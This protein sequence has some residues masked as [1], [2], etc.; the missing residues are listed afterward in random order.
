MRELL[1][2][3]PA[4]T[5][6]LTI[7]L[8]RDFLDPS[9]ARAPAAAH[10][11]ER[12]VANI[13]TMLQMCRE[14]G[15]PVVDCYVSR[16]PQ[17]AALGGHHAPYSAAG[18]ARCSS[19]S[20]SASM[21]GDDRHQMALELMAGGVAGCL[22][23]GSCTRN[24]PSHT[25]PPRPPERASALLFRL[26]QSFVQLRPNVFGCVG[27]AAPLIA[28]DQRT[29]G[30]HTGDTGQSNPLPDAVHDRQCA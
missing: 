10:I 22:P 8:Q 5:V 20:V 14:S 16:R 3:D 19:R 23:W 24:S 29:A 7:Y 27:V 30:H 1:V 2:I 25:Q 21:R 11:A 13:A 17:E 4:K 9:V 28:C 12:V 26:R 6:A 15:I 18:S